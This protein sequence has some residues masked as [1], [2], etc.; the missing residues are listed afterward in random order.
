MPIKVS[1]LKK[2]DESL[3]YATPMKPTDE[4]IVDFLKRN[5]DRAYTSKEIE[6]SLNKRVVLI[7]N[8]KAITKTGVYHA[9]K[10]LLDSPAYK[11]HLKKK[12]SYYYWDEST[13]Q[14]P[15]QAGLEGQS[16]KAG[17]ESDNRQKVAAQVMQVH[18]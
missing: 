16:G 5:C 6:K 12:G 17:R 11:I 15:R 10:K 4:Q 3:C 9:I 8:Q 13:H 14:G 1:D 2:L 7:P 18:S